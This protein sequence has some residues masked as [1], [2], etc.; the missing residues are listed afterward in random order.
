[1]SNDYSPWIP[2]FKFGVISV[3][4]SKGHKVFEMRGWGFLTGEGFGGL[5]LEM[6]EAESIQERVGNLIATAMNKDAG[7]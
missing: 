3:F 5:K 1:M 4:D 7:L 2:P 6:N